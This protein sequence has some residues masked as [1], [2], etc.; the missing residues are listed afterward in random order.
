MHERCGSWVVNNGFGMILACDLNEMV[1][2]KVAWY[3]Y[4]M[5]F[6]IHGLGRMSWDGLHM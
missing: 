3:W 4:E 5:K 1:G 2:I 6:Y